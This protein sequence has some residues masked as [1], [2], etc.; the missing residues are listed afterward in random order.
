MLYIRHS[1]K[2]HKNGE[3]PIFPLDPDL[4][5]HGKNLAKNKFQF[6]YKKFG[7]PKKI[8][9]SPF[10]RTRQTAQIAQDIIYEN[11]G[12]LVEIYVDNFLGEFV[13]NK[14]KFIDK[15]SALTPET[16]Q[17]DPFYLENWNQFIERINYFTK[18]NNNYDNTWYIT[19]GLIIQCISKNMGKKISYPGILEGF[20]IFN[21]QII[22]I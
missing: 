20:T 5:D 6:L 8:I 14:H 16:L 17:Y 3:S 21:G 11:T 9:T 12:C 18:N 13:S 19:H 7:T 4:T 1:E 22:T 2:T 15:S 10:L